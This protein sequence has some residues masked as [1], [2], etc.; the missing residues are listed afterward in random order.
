MRTYNTR[1]PIGLREKRSSLLYIVE[2][3]KLITDIN[4]NTH[5][6]LYHVPIIIASEVAANACDRVC[7][8]LWFFTFHMW[9]SCL[10]LCM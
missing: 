1:T 8:R 7:R 9:L 6:T 10:H 4:F 5:T 2:E 3:F